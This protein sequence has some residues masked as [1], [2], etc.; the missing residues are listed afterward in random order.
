MIIRRFNYEFCRYCCF[1]EIGKTL[2]QELATGVRNKNEPK[3]IRACAEAEKDAIIIKSEGEAEAIRNIGKAEVYLDNLK[4]RSEMVNRNIHLIEEQN[5]ESVIN[6]AVPSLPSD[7]STISFDDLWMYRFIQSSKSAFDEQVQR[8]WARILRNEA[9]SPG[10]YSPRTLSLLSNF[11]HSDAEMVSLLFDY[12]FYAPDH[13]AGLLFRSE[14]TSP[15]FFPSSLQDSLFSFYESVD[16]A[17]PD[18]LV[19]DSIGIFNFESRGSLF[20]FGEF[21]DGGCFGVL[22]F[23]GKRIGFTKKE[24]EK[25]LLPI[26]PLSPFALELSTLYEPKRTDRFDEFMGLVKQLSYTVLILDDKP[27]NAVRHST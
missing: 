27:I 16:L 26:I 11:S 21:F 4:R 6:F 2:I 7:L 9:V 1:G 23:Q 25:I 22:N 14:F 12:C 3:R 10:Q 19:L 24:K 17:Y 15:P 5:L 13:A 18:L 20:R 8:L